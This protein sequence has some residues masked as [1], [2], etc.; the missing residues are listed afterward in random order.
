MD[1]SQSGTD[2]SSRSSLVDVGSQGLVKSLKVGPVGYVATP[3]AHHQLEE[4]GWTQWGGIKEYLDKK[5]TLIRCEKV[6]LATFD[7]P[8]GRKKTGQPVFGEWIK[9]KPRVVKIWSQ[10]VLT[11][12]PW[13]LKN[14]PVFSMT[15]SSDSRL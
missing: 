6:R 5:T 4:R 1:R 3:T 14:S 2:P 8:T 12:L 7:L 11:C 15:C 10:S 13:F 9:E